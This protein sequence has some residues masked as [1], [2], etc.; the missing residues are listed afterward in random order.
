[1]RMPSAKCFYTDHLL[2]LTPLGERESMHANE[3]MIIVYG[4]EEMVV[5]FGGTMVLFRKI[6][7]SRFCMYTF[8]FC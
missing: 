1:M 2:S 7:R 3:Y 6:D 5:P 8:L 4:K